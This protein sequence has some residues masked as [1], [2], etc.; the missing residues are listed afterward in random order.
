VFSIYITNTDDHLRNHGFL[1]TEKGW[2]LS[3]AYDVNPIE[4]GTGL[5][6][7]I[8]EDDNSLDVNLALE[9]A[10]YFRLSK[11]TAKNIISEIQSIVITWKDVQN[12]TVSLKLSKK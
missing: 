7:N 10:P 5:T 1:L 2:V 8:S 6:L 4:D 9:V 3:P 12:I 11:E